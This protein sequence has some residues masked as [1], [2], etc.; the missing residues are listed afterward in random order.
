MTAAQVADALDR[1]E[2]VGAPT[3][4]PE[5]ARRVWLSDTLARQIAAALRRRY[6]AGTC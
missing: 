4:E 6:G 2:R 5:G 1:A 3:D